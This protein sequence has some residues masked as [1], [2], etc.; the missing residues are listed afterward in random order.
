M[1]D[2][3]DM[4]ADILARQQPP[5][6]ASPWESV[7]SAVRSM[8]SGQPGDRRFDWAK[9]N[10]EL[11][12]SL[13]WLL[14]VAPM[15][16]RAGTGPSAIGPNDFLTAA[17]L[18]RGMDRMEGTPNPSWDRGVMGGVD[19]NSVYTVPGSAEAI[20]RDYRLSRGPAANVVPFGRARPANENAALF[21]RN[22]PDWVQAKQAEVGLNKELDSQ[23]QA[24]APWRRH[25]PDA[26]EPSPSWF[27]QFLNRLSGRD[28]EG[29]PIESSWRWRDR[30]ED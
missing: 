26:P 19:R 11:A 24:L 17:R 18:E 30:P 13:A 4:L 3:S 25:G 5:Q 15:G 28:K 20:A 12:K 1:A 27:D 8:G 6:P 21:D 10:P 16:L 22:V 14:S 7:L 9:Q 2:Q 29:N 23:M